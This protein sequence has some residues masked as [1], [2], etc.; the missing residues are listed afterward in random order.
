MLTQA[1]SMVFDGKS[2]T[3]SDCGK[4]VNKGVYSSRETVKF[5]RFLTYIIVTKNCTCYESVLTCINYCHSIVVI[6]YCVL[7][8]VVILISFLRCV[9]LIIV[10]LIRFM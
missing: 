8:I 1:L 9:I 7:S 4:N 3:V 10:V 5:K 6:V 2:K